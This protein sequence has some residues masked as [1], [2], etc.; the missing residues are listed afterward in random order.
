MPVRPRLTFPAD[1]A[2]A[3]QV[4]GAPEI[5]AGLTCSSSH[6]SAEVSDPESVPSSAAKI[7]AGIRGQARIDQ[8]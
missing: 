4:P 3:D 7:Q 1:H 2:D 6:S 8:H 5:A